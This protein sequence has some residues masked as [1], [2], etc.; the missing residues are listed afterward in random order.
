MGKSVY[1]NEDEPPM[2]V[3]VKARTAQLP[4]HGTVL[5]AIIE[6]GKLPYEVKDTA[7]KPGGHRRAIIPA[8]A[9]R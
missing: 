6:V 2:S 5:A 3:G 1:L 4:G 9:R 7:R 8:N